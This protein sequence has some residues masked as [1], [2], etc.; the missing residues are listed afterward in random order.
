MRLSLN[1]MF[2]NF[3]EN[4]GNSD[5][6]KNERITIIGRKNLMLSKTKNLQ[7]YPA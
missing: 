7:C 5:T 2:L 1:D 6:S 4:I 3:R